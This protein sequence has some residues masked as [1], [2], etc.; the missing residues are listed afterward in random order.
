LNEFVRALFDGATGYMEIREI[1]KAGNV[2]QLFLKRGEI[3]N[4][5]P[6]ND[7]NIYF[8]VYD[9]SGKM[10]PLRVAKAQAHYGLIMTMADH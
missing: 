6:P 10:E 7:K 9:R 4:Y 8:G 3:A 1:D 5:K 2:K